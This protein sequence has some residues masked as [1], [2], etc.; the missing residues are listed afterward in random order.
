MIAQGFT[1][2]K[3]P[4]AAAAVQSAP[5]RMRISKSTYMIENIRLKEAFKTALSSGILIDLK[6]EIIHKGMRRR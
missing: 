3:K 5:A 2:R 4:A 6:E 1:S